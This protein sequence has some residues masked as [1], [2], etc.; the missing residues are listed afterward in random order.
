MGWLPKLAREASQLSDRV[1]RPQT[2]DFEI[3]NIILVAEEIRFGFE[4][5][6]RICFTGQENVGKTGLTLFPVFVLSSH[7]TSFFRYKSVF[8]LST[9]HFDICLISLIDKRQFQGPKMKRD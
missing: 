4:V 2:W 1:S 8:P 3:G 9:L 5:E 6:I 7:M